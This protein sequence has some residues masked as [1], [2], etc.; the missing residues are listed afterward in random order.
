MPDK[1]FVGSGKSYGQYGQI[2]I[3]V[4][5]DDIHQDFITTDRKGKQWVRLNVCKKRNPEPGGDEFYVEVN[6]WKPDNQ[7]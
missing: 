7:G 3:K 2:G 4:C 1:I 6:T 5:I